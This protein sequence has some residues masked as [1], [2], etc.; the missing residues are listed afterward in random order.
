MA[1]KLK[2]GV[3]G[4]GMMGTTHLDIYAQM[5]EVEVVAIADTNPDLLDG[6]LQAKG[7]IEGQ[8]AGS[9]KALNVKKYSDGMGLIS[10]PKVELV[11]ICVGTHLH[12]SFVEAALIQEKH[13][14]IEKPLARSAEQARRIVELAKCSTKVVMSAMCLRYWPAWLW[15]KKAIDDNRFG[16]CLSL[17]CRRHTSHP[18]GDFYSNSEQCGGA[19]LDLHIHDT[20]FINF[21]FGMPQAV[22][23]QGHLGPSGGIDYVSTQYI[24]NQ[25]QRAIVHAE[26]TWDLQE[27]YGFSMSYTANFENAT[28]NYVLADEETLMLFVAGD[29]PKNVELPDGM[30]YEFE[31]RECVDTILE[32]RSTDMNLLNQAA[33]SLVIIEAEQASIKYCSVVPIKER[34]D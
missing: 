11:D 6:S 23:S 25:A 10:D 17:N 2:V 16:A 9:V 15:L 26:G 29:E 22:F 31:I 1:R 8:A 4:L 27:G 32:N 19:L 20:D 28:L 3:I 7:N 18:P 5:S 34:L 13:V 24:Y 12:F 33:D 21:C 14:L 30:G